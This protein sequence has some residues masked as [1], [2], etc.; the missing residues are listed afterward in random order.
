MYLILMHDEPQQGPVEDTALAN[1]VGEAM[2]LG[3]S[4]DRAL[5]IG[6][7][8]V[9]ADTEKLVRERLRHGEEVDRPFAES[10]QADRRQ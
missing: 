10:E 3:P 1:A 7:W 2:G 9:S 6:V 8:P 5:G 4:H